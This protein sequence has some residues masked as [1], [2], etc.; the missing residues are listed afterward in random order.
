MQHKTRAFTLIELL[1]VIAIIAILA[2]I[3]FP[4]FAQ[5]REQART[6][7]SLMQMRQIGLALQMYVDEFDSTLPLT[8]TGS[9]VAADGRPIG[10]WL[11]WKHHIQPYMK[12]REV[13]RDPVNPAREVF[14]E[15]SDPRNPGFNPNRPFDTFRSY[16]YYRAFHITGSWQDRAPY[17]QSAI[18]NPSNA[19]VFSENK[20]VFPDYGPWMRY[21]PRGVGTWRSWSNWGGGKREDKYF[22]VVFADSSARM[23][24]M[25]RT[26]GAP[27]AL[28]MW[29]YDP[30]VSYR[31]FPIE[32]QPA[33]IEW[34][35]TFCNT[36]PF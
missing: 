14:D 10:P 31:N 33:D 35:K 13:I 29:Q 9:G 26:C 20:D 5:A 27:G 21:I 32:G 7:Q 15:T 12:N 25:R 19:L 8:R 30:G 16:F 1:V 3:L 6:T 22:V 28:N 24:P 17:M 4:V 36:L 2:A 23:V 11:N 18:E 34:I